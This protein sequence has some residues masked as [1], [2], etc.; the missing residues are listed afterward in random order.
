MDCTAI[1]K[2]TEGTLYDKKDKKGSPSKTE[3]A[4]KNVGNRPS[5]CERWQIRA[6]QAKTATGNAG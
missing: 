1:Q 2:E 4:A 6:G 5:V 3:N